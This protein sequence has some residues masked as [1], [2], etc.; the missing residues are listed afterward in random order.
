MADLYWTIAKGV[1]AE[2]HLFSGLN[3]A[4]TREVVRIFHDQRKQGP[5]IDGSRVKSIA[6]SAPFGTRVILTTAAE[7]L[8]QEHPWRALCFVEGEK[9]KMREGLPVI[10]V[11]DLDAMDDPKAPRHDPEMWV[12]YPTVAAP[13]DGKGWT[14]GKIV[15]DREIKT[16]L[17][18]IRFDKIPA[19][20]PTAAVPE[21]VVQPGSP[22]AMD[23]G[24][25]LAE[26]EAAGPGTA[27]KAKRKRT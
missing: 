6:L 13:D 15:F 22:A 8:W 16:H 19:P 9:F 25:A 1:V 5:E 17:K 10:Q 18:G 7:P 11:P 26:G 23:L 27:P 2:L 12:G 14:Y 4:G 3:F 20:K 24:S 21:P